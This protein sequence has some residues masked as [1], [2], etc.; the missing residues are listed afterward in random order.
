LGD[1]K[2]LEKSKY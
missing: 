2:P 1:K